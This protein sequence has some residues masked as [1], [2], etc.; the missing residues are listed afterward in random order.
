MTQKL[1]PVSYT[2]LLNTV[3]EVLGN[4][5]DKVTGEETETVN[6]PIGTD[7]INVVNYKNIEFVKV[8]GDDNT[9]TLAGAVFEIHYKEKEDGEY[10]APVSYTHLDVYKRQVSR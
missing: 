4:V 3:T 5:A 8:D 2:H 7:P 1:I 9:K 6:E 10:A